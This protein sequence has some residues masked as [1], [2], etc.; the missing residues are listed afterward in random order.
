MAFIPTPNNARVAIR[1]SLFGQDI[2]NTLWFEGTIPFNDTLLASLNADVIA[3][4]DANL[5]PLLSDDISLEE[6]T[7][8]AQDS[9]TAPSASTVA[10]LPGTAAGGSAPGNVCLT[11]TFKTF[12]R[13][14]SGRGRNYVSGIREIDING[15]AVNPV[16]AANLRT[17]YAQIPNEI[18]TN[19]AIHTVVS[20][21]SNH[22]PR[23]EGL[24]QLIT[25]YVV[26][27][28]NIDSQRRRLTGRG[29]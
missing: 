8:I 14:R 13:G 11:V 24:P 1:Q 26:V 10:I 3:W 27:D 5:R 16:F 29:S 28:E 15:N 12:Q 21:Q 20:F 6:V 2:I 22:V 18:I 17:A 19:G 25:E 23:T 9:L 7:S 4:W